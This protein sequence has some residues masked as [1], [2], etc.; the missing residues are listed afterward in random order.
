MQRL[1]TLRVLVGQITYAL[2]GHDLNVATV[3]TCLQLFN[4]SPGFTYLYQ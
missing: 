1:T 4:V 3:F 2:T